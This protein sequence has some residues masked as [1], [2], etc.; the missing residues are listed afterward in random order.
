MFRY[1]LW[2]NICEM[3]G[4][5]LGFSQWKIQKLWTRFMWNFHFP[6]INPFSIKIWSDSWKLHNNLGMLHSLLCLSGNTYGAS[7][8]CRYGSPDKR[9]IYIFNKCIY[10]FWKR[11]GFA[12]LWRRRNPMICCLQAGDPGKLLG[13][14]GQGTKL[15]L[16]K[17]HCLNLNLKQGKTDVPACRQAEQMLLL[18]FFVLFRRNARI[19]PSADWTRPTHNRGAVYL[20]LPFK[21]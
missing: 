1:V 15:R 3:I 10:D 4:R 18:S 20:P 11:I 14:C 9:N 7:V 6:L 12:W 2:S 8:L 16:R 13:S 19:K 17:K 21:C 5:V